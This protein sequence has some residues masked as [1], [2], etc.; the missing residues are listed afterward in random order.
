MN[1][2]LVRQLLHTLKAPQRSALIASFTLWGLARVRFYAVFN[3]GEWKPGCAESENM[4]TLMEVMKPTWA[5]APRAL[6]KE[7]M[8]HVLQTG[9]LDEDP[10]LFNNG[11]RL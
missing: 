9:L 6:F 11:A 4:R 3:A 10:V 7:A 8:V 1:P 2:T 5:A